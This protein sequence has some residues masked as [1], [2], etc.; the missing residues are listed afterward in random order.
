MYFSKSQFYSLA[1]RVKYYWHLQAFKS[2]KTFNEPVKYNEKFASY[3]LVL[4]KLTGSSLYIIE[5]DDKFCSMV[6]FKF[7]ASIHLFNK[8]TY[9]LESRKT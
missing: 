5:P 8:N 4:T 2:G 6:S 3:P 1:F 7:Y 9:M